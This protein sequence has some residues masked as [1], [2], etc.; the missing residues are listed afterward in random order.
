VLARIVSEGL[1]SY[2]DFVHSR[3]TRSPARSIGYSDEEWAWSVA[4]ERIMIAA[5][6]PILM[7]KERRDLDRI[8]HRRIALVLGGP[9]AGGYFIG[10]R[11]VDAYVTRHPAGAWHDLLAMPVREAL[12][13]SGYELGAQVLTSQ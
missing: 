11:I 13:Q 9:T 6:G 3:G 7:S 8:T 4:N 2:A 5:V 1:A 12:R 10:F